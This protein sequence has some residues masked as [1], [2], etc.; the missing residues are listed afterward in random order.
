MS[1]S[2]AVGILL[3][4]VLVEALLIALLLDLYVLG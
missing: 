4:T 3:A 1:D 2:T